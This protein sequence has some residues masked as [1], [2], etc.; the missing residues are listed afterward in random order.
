[1]KDSRFY[2]WFALPILIIVAV[3]GGAFLLKDVG[4]EYLVE[5]TDYIHSTDNPDKCRFIAIA[6]DRNYTISRIDKDRAFAEKK[7]ICKEC[8]TQ[9][10][11][12]EYNR[13]LQ[14][15]IKHNQFWDEQETWNKLSSKQ[16]V[17]YKKLIVYMEDNG[18]MHI[19]G[20]CY[21]IRNSKTTRIQL[22]LIT[23]FN[24]TC[25]DCVGREYCDFIYKKVYEGIY[26]TSQIKDGE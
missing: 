5:C 7:K 6:K 13:L 25:E 10:E 12:D 22:D 15:K 21:N 2:I 9:Q 11:Q 19:D 16:N 4:K 3:I 14:W 24:T 23:R 17:D 8:Y 20:D 18:T 26:D 1:M